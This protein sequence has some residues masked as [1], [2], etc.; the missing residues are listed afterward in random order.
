M[1]RHREQRGTQE[2]EG[3][4][5]GERSGGREK[6]GDVWE[7]WGNEREL[8]SPGEWR[9]AQEVAGGAVWSGKEHDRG[10]GGPGRMEHGTGGQGR[11]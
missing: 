9:S 6:M 7:V 2:D 10:Q 3:E 11:G 8:G 5:R 4:R 1:V